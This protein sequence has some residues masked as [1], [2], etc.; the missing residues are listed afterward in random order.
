MVFLMT[1]EHSCRRLITHAE[2][3]LGNFY[4][5]DRVSAASACEG[6]VERFGEVKAPRKA[7]KSRETSGEQGSLEKR[8]HPGKRE[9]E[10]NQW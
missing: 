5:Q 2:N 1:Q 4:A 7:G 3:M 9:K 10:E 6:E 8:E